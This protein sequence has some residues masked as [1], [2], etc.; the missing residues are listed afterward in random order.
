MTF[1]FFSLSIQEI[2]K[3]ITHLKQAIDNEIQTHVF[4]DS[5]IARMDPNMVLYQLCSLKK[6]LNQNFILSVMLATYKSGVFYITI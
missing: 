1:T 4:K 2:D 5:I 3:A 6:V